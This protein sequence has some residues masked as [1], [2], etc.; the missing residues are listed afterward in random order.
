MKKVFNG[1]CALAVLVAFAFIS[2]GF[3]PE[4]RPKTVIAT[5]EVREEITAISSEENLFEKTMSRYRVASSDEQ[6]SI[7]GI[8]YDDQFAGVWYDYD[9][10]LNIGVTNEARAESRSSEVV[11]H[12]RQFSYN[13]LNEV[14][15]AIGELM[16][17]YSIFSVGMTPQYNQVRVR[18]EVEKDIDNVIKHLSRLSLF[19]EGSIDFIVEKVSTK[20]SRPIY[21]GG[22]LT[23]LIG[24][25]TISAKAIC[26]LTGRSGIITNAHVAEA[27]HVMSRLEWVNGGRWNREVIGTRAQFQFSG[28]ADA[29]FIPFDNPDQ[30]ELASSASYFVGPSLPRNAN[31]ITVVPKTYQ[32]ATRNE[33]QVGR[34]VAQFGDTTGRTDGRISEIKTTVNLHDH[35]GVF[36][37]RFTD[38]FRHTATTATGDSGGPVFWTNGGQYIL[39]GTHFSS[40][41]GASKITN[42]RSV[43]DVT[44][45]SE[46]FVMPTFSS[47]SNSHG[48]ITA[49]HTPANAHRA[50]DGINGSDNQWRVSSRTGWVQLNLN[51]DIIV[52]SIEF[53]NIHHGHIRNG[54]NGARFWTGDPNVPGVVPLGDA[55]N[56][57]GPLNSSGGHRT[58]HV[59]GIRT[60][61]IRLNIISSYE[62]APWSTAD[63]GASEIIIHATIPTPQQLLHNRGDYTTISGDF[64]G[65]GTDDIAM[66]IT[67]GGYTQLHVWNSGTTYAGVV[68]QESANSFHL[69]RIT[70]R[71]VA[72]DFNGDGYCDIVVFYDYGNQVTALLKW[73]GSS[74]GLTHYFVVDTRPSFIANQI[75]GRVVAGDFNGNGYDDI[76]AFYDYGGSVTAILM[77]RGTAAGLNYAG[78]V[79]EDNQFFAHAITGRVVAGDFNGD[80]YDDIAVMYCYGNMTIRIHIWHGT[81]TG[82]QFR[83]GV[84]TDTEF[85][86]A[87]VT[88]RMVAGDFNGDGRD[89]IAVMY[90]Y[91]GTNTMRIHVWYRTPTGLQFQWGVSHHS[92]FI[93]SLVT[94][95]VVVGDF[96][97]DGKTD[98]VAFYD[99]SHTPT[100]ESRILMWHG[101]TNGLAYAGIVW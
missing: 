93:S 62:V 20:E 56:A 47:N 81:S 61:V 43:L 75:T 70:G 26:N 27:G 98:I 13:F 69:D 21:S 28:L 25:G 42:V 6:S 48:H 91:H 51:Y 71:V 36:L 84:S 90:D 64:N 63:I 89:D 11:Y 65:D 83:W 3:A 79:Y 23:S 77:W 37:A 16:S 34:P 59:G 99:Y 17:E 68:W 32:V 9:D 46:N 7:N 29:A 73:N 72:G 97:G 78:I 41:G 38:Q 49:S 30:W 92:S 22:G 1:F 12:T 55:F 67:N 95:R 96:N 60:N 94:G 18:L 44:I 31:D 50:F 100:N 24:R 54:T 86:A 101:I 10:K 8:L 58:I 80:G 57:P 14:H 66:F 2:C 39:V 5:T 52:H 74:S 87:M 19:E 45:V 4:N 53:Y 85:N 82:F 33:I 15:Y 35:N 40:G 76:A 88:G